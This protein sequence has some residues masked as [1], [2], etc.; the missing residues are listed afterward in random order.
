MFFK[1]WKFLSPA[2][3]API[4]AALLAFQKICDFV[5]DLEVKNGEDYEL[6]GE[7]FLRF[8]N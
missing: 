2:E 6:Q 7:L 1:V 5:D 4:R 3:K 8:C